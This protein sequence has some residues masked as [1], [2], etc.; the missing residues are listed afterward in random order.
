MADGELPPTDAEPG[1]V[2]EPDGEGETLEPAAPPGPDEVDE[3]I[4]PVP[5]PPPG[6]FLHLKDGD[7]LLALVTKK[8]T[9]GH[10]KP[11]D[12][13]PV[14]DEIKWPDHKAEPYVL[15][16]EA[17]YYLQAMWE[18]AQQDGVNLYINSAFETTS[19]GEYC[20]V[21]TYPEKAVMKKPPTLKAL[22]QANQNTSW[23]LL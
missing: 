12:L 1:E 10:Y 6:E 21:I 5:E 8:T 14:P 4:P 22:V 3:E 15:R 9:L 11:A 16:E 7:Y 13:V 23:E 20:F 19:T 18:A 2:E 17:N